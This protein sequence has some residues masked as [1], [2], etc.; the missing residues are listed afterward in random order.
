MA[1]SPPNG[2]GTGASVGYSPDPS[3]PPSAQYS[4]GHRVTAIPC[5][6]SSKACA[7]LRAPRLSPGPLY[8]PRSVSLVGLARRGVIPQNNSTSKCSFCDPVVLG[9]VQPRRRVRNYRLAGSAQHPDLRSDIGPQFIRRELETL[10]YA[11]RQ[12]PD[13]FFE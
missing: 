13:G 6:S 3:G 2:V 5:S 12:F 4:C 10:A 8:M 11:G 7:G 1:P 9:L